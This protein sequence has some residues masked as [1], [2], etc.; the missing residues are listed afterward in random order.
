MSQTKKAVILAGGYGTRLYPL[1][2]TRAKSLL[3]IAGVPLIRRLVGYL[4]KN[5]FETIVITLNNFSE[6]IRQNLKGMDSQ[7]DIILSEEPTP[8]GTA[9]SVK[10]AS[11]YFD[12]SFLVIQGDTVTDFDLSRAKTFH[13]SHGEAATIL[14]REQVDVAGLGVVDLDLESNVSQFVEKPTFSDGRARLISTGIYLLEPSVLEHV[15]PGQPF[16]FAKDLFP[17]LLRAGVKIKGAR[18]D[19]YW[20]DMGT[21]RAY[22]D[23]SMWYLESFVRQSLKA[24]GYSDP[25]V[26]GNSLVRSGSY[27]GPG[28]RVDN[29]VIEEGAVVENGALISNS[30]VLERSKIEAGARIDSAIIGEDCKIGSGSSVEFGAVLGGQV[31][32]KPNASVGGGSVISAKSVVGPTFAQRG[33]LERSLPDRPRPLPLPR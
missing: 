3:P 2:Q 20:I 12:D 11:R 23:A 27:V 31:I 30:I 7:A 10:Y 1:T 21:T 16:D 8:L 24:T 22:L 15:P 14:L 28:A 32:V 29:C 9:G 33:P 26:V 5:G 18:M 13:S 17:K 25:Q 6:Q 19:G 4:E